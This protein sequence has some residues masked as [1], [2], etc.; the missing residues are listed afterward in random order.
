MAK[1]FTFKQFHID[2]FQCGMPVSTDA[3]LLG[4][5]ADIK[6]AK[7]LLDIGCGTGIL[8]IMCAQ[9]NPAL[10]INAVEIEENAF[11]AATLNMKSCPWTNRCSVEHTDIEE[12]VKGG[13]EFDTIICNPPY[14]NDGA[15]SDNSQR[16]VARHTATLSHAN[17]LTFCV[18]L[19]KE[20]GNASFILPKEEGLAFLALLE[21]EVDNK[22]GIKGLHLSNLTT[23]QT[24]INK[25]ATRVLIEL[26]K[27]M[28][29]VVCEH[30]ELIIHDGKGYSDAFIELTSA[31]YLKM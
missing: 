14:F 28:L 5:W 20:E 16:A 23:V 3:V 10:Q 27:S 17:L 6:K 8:S 9:R 22:V 19:L 12:F 29:P 11:N 13:R 4:A 18:Q 24:T 30:N 26:T 21:S 1:G 2:A 25:P 31:F 7:T 15:A